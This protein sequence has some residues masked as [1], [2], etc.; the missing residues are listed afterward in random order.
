MVERIAGLLERVRAERPLVHN[1]TNYVVM[2]NTANA[3]LALGASPVMAHAGEEVVEMTGLAGALV[4]NIGTLSPA[5]VEAMLA[6]GRAASARGI[7]VVLD[8]VGAGATAYRSETALRLLEEIRVSILRGNAGEVGVLAGLG[9]AVKGVDSAGA[10][11]AGG[12]L[13]TAAARR[14]G[15]VAVATGPVD[16]VGDGERVAEV[17]NGHPLLSLVTG[18]GCTATALTG[19]FAAVTGDPF[20]AAV[21]TL[22]CFGVA[23]EDAAAAPAVRGPGSYQVALLDA[24][25]NLTPARVREAARLEVR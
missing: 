1:I 22:V 20:L 15:T 10:A 14:F 3:L 17:H 25:H 18:T 12:E 6:A 19:A 5:W 9:G 13:V 23:A 24:L 21:A 16:Y 4:L 11:A 2:N 7:P 8:P